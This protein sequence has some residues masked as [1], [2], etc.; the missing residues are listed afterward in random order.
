[1]LGSWISSDELG[2]GDNDEI[3]IAHA[4]FVHWCDGNSI[5]DDG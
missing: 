5:K 1:M 2:G 4:M 3:D